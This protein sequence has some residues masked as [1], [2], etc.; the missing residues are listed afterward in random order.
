M[1]IY[2]SCCAKQIIGKKEGGL[3][4]TACLKTQPIRAIL[5]GFQSMILSQ[6]KSDKREGT[7]KG[8]QQQL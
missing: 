8:R 3:G 4:W 2:D 6:L 1:Q 7:E 5:K